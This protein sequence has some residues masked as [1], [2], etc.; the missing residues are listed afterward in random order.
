MASPVVTWSNVAPPFWISTRPTVLS[1]SATG[2]GPVPTAKV[3][4]GAVVG[5]AY[6][7]T[8]TAQGGTAPYTFAMT[9][10]SLPTGLSLNAT[11]GVISG[12]PTTVQTGDFTIQAT[13]ANGAAGPA[14]NFEIGV[15]APTGGGAADY[16]W[17]N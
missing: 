10:G 6:S 3:L 14:V 1:P 4:Q 16:G 11:T 8:V 7:E 15:T 12:T 9:A 17:V 5:V 2:A 13:D